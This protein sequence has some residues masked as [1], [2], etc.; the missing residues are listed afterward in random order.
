MMEMHQDVSDVL[1]LYTA[2]V[3]VSDSHMQQEAAT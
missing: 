1:Y 3:T 2:E